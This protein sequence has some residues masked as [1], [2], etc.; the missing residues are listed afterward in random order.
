[1]LPIKR[2][3]V[4]IWALA[5]VV[6]PVLYASVPLAGVMGRPGWRGI[7]RTVFP[8]TAG[9]A[10]PCSIPFPMG[11]DRGLGSE[12]AALCPRNARAIYGGGVCY[13]PHR[14]GVVSPTVCVHSRS[15][16]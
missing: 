2:M 3:A 10:D 4:W 13:D 8:S 7:G 16:A 9:A 6:A 12:G 11:F 15:F 5:G 1:M 14:L